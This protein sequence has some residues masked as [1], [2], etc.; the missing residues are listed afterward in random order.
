MAPYNQP[1][2][3]AG[4]QQSSQPMGHGEGAPPG[5]GYQSTVQQ[6]PPVSQMDVPTPTLRWISIGHPQEQIPIGEDDYVLQSVFNHQIDAWEIL[7]LVQP[8]EGDEDEEE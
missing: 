1:G 7:V 5:S 3:P 8:E 4:Q 6:A 2:R